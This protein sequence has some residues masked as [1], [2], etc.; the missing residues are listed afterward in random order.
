MQ[1]PLWAVGAGQ[2][3]RYRGRARRT[4]GRYTASVTA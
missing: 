2:I 3:L 4:Y 1:F